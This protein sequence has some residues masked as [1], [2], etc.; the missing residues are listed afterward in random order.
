M[1]KPPA[2][3]WPLVLKGMTM[4]ISFSP[5]RCDTR[6]RVSVLGD[7]IFVNDE[8]FDF[9]PLAEGATLPAEAVN[10]DWFTG[11]ITRKDG[12]I[13]VVLV[14]PH[15]AVAPKEARFPAPVT[16]QVDGPVALPAH[17]V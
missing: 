12:C 6:L 9:S 8:P 16:T 1:H 11:P 2:R 13:E 5:V 17:E 4:K 7:T 10:S 3:P 15:G 14:L